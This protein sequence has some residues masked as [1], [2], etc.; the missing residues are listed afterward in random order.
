[1]SINRM[2]KA[3]LYYITYYYLYIEKIANVIF[4]SDSNLVIFI[5]EEV[6]F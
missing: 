3:K 5:G 2:K 4:Q 1:M 6:L